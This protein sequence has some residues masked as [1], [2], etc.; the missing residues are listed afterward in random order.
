MIATNNE[1]KN[2]LIESKG[3]FIIFPHTLNNLNISCGPYHF[4]LA[5]YR[6]LTFDVGH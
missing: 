5:G 1:L 4:E 6:M 2:S 3:L